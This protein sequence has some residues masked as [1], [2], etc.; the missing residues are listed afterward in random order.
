MS[1]LAGL[2]HCCRQRVKRLHID[3]LQCDGVQALANK[4][5]T[6]GR[7]RRPLTHGRPVLYRRISKA[8]IRTLHTSVPSVLFKR[9]S[10]EGRNKVILS[11]LLNLQYFILF[12]VH[13]STQV[14]VTKSKIYWL[15][16]IKAV[17][18]VGLVVANAKRVRGPLELDCAQLELGQEQRSTHASDVQAVPGVREGAKPLTGVHKGAVV[19]P[20]TKLNSHDLVRKWPAAQSMTPIFT[21]KVMIFN[22]RL[23]RIRTERKGRGEFR[24]A[25]RALAK[26]TSIFVTRTMC[27]CSARARPSVHSSGRTLVSRCL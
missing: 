4:G 16:V 6:L 9:L 8:H 17:R 13:P 27:I 12:Y 24:K 19:T 20:G 18:V 5:E 11:G 26:S 3:A 14:A 15:A 1:T 10:S 2:L 22:G 23:W 21:P 7:E 25:A